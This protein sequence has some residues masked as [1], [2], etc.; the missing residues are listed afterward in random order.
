[1]KNNI[2]WYRSLYLGE[3]AGMQKNIWKKLQGGLHSRLHLL[4]LPSNEANLLDILPQSVL[5]QEHYKRFPLYVVGA[6]WTKDEA[7]ELAGKIITEVYGATGKTDVAAYL[8]DD[9]LPEPE[10]ASEKLYRE[11]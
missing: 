5:M 4:V 7:M 3:K 11:W 2:R 9:F 8:G 10:P 1:M 6:A